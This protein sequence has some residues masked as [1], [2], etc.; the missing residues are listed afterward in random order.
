MIKIIKLG[1]KIQDWNIW[2]GQ[3]NL[4]MMIEEGDYKWMTNTTYKYKN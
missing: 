2:M 1:M 4:G 3:D